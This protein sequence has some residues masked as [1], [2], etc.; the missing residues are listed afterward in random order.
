VPGYHGDAQEADL[1]AREAGKIGFPVLIKASAGGGGKGMR[2]VRHAA[3]FAEQLASCQREAAASFGD[4]RVLIERYVEGP[5]HVEF[6]VFGDRHGECIHLF[7]R[8]CSV[9]RRHQKVLE[10]APAPGMTADLRER[11]GAAAV[12]AA[13]AVHYVGAGT[14]EFILAPD[15]SFY[16]MEMNTRL[17]VEHPVTELI[18]GL[19]LVEWQLRIA[20]GERL[21][22]T[23]ADVQIDGHAIE[24]RV[25]AE[26]PDKG[27]L[28]SIG[29][30]DYV[31]PPIDRPYVRVDS[32][33]EPGDQ[34]T[35]YYDP[36]I[37]KLILWGATREEARQRLHD[38]L[39]RYRVVGVTTN[40][41]FLAR[42]VETDSFKLPRLDTA[43]IER[44]RSVLDAARPLP[45][46]ELWLLAALAVLIDDRAAAAAQAA[47]RG[48][49][50]NPWFDVG[51]WRANLRSVRR[52]ELQWHDA[53]K[54][55]EVEAAPDRMRFS[56]TLDGVVAQVEGHPSNATIDGAT[57][58]GEVVSD[59][60]NRLHVFAGPQR[61][62]FDRPRRSTA[63]DGDAGDAG[64]HLRAPIPGRVV[65][66]VATVGSAVT[67]GAPL[68][69]IEAMKMEHTIVAPAAGTVAAIHFAIGDAV[70]EGADLI[71]LVPN[72]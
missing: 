57:V 29:Q 23:Q 40:L 20:A 48:D 71:E 70:K 65:R 62:V 33:V 49:A 1:L 53:R 2:I 11:M 24:A 51:G 47:T 36:M 58:A 4:D 31:L 9:Q 66:V 61:A 14:I 8:D 42:L 38:A 17:Q 5:R 59:G 21:P 55:L 22:L 54:V 27:F 19:D 32:G 12:A 44:E 26:D 43:L 7:E 69:I 45:S 56:I 15:Q 25:Y 10:E 46:R 72:E 28:P 30:L 50:S 34:I 3:E 60:K 64:A 16:F 52:I 6:Q 67:K 39:R 37:A 13:R 35:P 63:H 41:D 18:T 68:M